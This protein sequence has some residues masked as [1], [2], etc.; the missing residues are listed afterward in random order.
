MYIFA[1]GYAFEVIV[2][3]SFLGW[4]ISCVDSPG[5]PVRSCLVLG[6]PL[7]EGKSL[8]FSGINSEYKSG[9]FGYW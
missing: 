6:N 8:D 1:V 7:L 3:F 9:F 2:N 4:K 5:E